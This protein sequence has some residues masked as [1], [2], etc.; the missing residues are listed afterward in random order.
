MRRL[1]I[2]VTNVAIGIGFL[3]G[4]GTPAVVADDLVEVIPPIE[5]AICSSTNGLVAFSAGPLRD[6]VPLHGS[7]YLGKGDYQD[8]KG[9]FYY[10]GKEKSER[11]N[12]QERYLYEFSGQ[13]QYDT[14]R[15]LC[16]PD[17]PN[18]YGLIYLR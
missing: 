3:I 11:T 15:D 4:T 8:A 1:G 7:F 12:H 17:Y 14:K 5:P 18:S 16:N 6:L 2:W 9:L 10:V 13:V